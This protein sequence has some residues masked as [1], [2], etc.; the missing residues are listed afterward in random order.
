MG[1]PDHV[2]SIIALIKFYLRN[3]QYLQ[4]DIWAHK[5]KQHKHNDIA[6]VKPSTGR[7]RPWG[8]YTLAG[9]VLPASR[10]GGNAS[11]W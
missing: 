8:T 6:S 9:G 5:L 7:E 10:Q 2:H 3:E 11:V 1:E 4:A